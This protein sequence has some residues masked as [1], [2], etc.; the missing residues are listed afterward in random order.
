MPDAFGNGDAFLAKVVSLC[1]LSRVNPSVT[2]CTPANNSTV[3]S[4]VTV[5]AGT[6]DS[7]LV[8]LTQVYL[9][10]H[11]IYQARLSAISV[12]LPIAAGLHR[13]TVQAVETSGFTF[14]KSLTIGVNP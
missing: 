4:P 9:D 11:K 5:T 2:I 12:R 13:L 14:K 8:A 3:N 7:R 6:T 1:A 10:G